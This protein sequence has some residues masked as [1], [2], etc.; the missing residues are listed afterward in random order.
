V[1]NAPTS[2][3]P[4]SAPAAP[5]SGPD[6]DASDAAFRN[7]VRKGDLARARGNVDE[8]I[9]AYL[10]ALDL[11]DD[12]TVN[13]RL[14]LIGAMVDLPAP[15]ATRLSRA[16]EGGGGATSMEKDAFF[17]AFKRVR[18]LVCRLLINGNVY[19]A[20][21][22][23]DAAEFAPGI[24][25]TYWLFITPGKH[26]VR[27]QS[28][29][30]GEVSVVVNCPAGGEADVFLEWK[31]PEPPPVAPAP[32]AAPLQAAPPPPPL[33]APAFRHAVAIIQRGDSSSD[34]PW[35]SDDRTSEAPWPQRKASRMHGSVGV[36]PAL[37]LGAASWRPSFGAMLSGSLRWSALSINADARAAW[38]TYGIGGQPIRAMTAGAVLSGCGH[39]RWLFGCIAAHLGMVRVEATGDAYTSESFTGFK[40]GL[41]MRGGAD[42]PLP[43]GFALRIAG[44]VVG[45]PGGTRIRVGSRIIADQ[46]PI[47]VGAN[48]TGLWLF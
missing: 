10:K 22:A 3:P 25:P 35:A 15:A 4:T 20:E 6:K 8:A 14:G 32:D 39:W 11:H 18:P 27:G 2:N 30:H 28:A 7:L 23:I 24:G 45:L 12:P 26:V 34:D 46:P 37:V 31:L 44:D 47:L 38:L 5:S 42:I 36:G 13:G 33:P 9:D 1:S 16:I 43:G 17:Q 29:I 41:G 19:E 40:P 21:T 48:V